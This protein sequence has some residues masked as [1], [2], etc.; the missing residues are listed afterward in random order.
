MS[1]V[2]WHLG[3]IGRLGLL[4]IAAVGLSA[5]ET[6]PADDG[7]ETVSSRF[8]D[9]NNRYAQINEQSSDRFTDLDI[10]GAVAGLDDD[11]VMYAIT[12]AGAEERVRGKDAVRASL[13]QTFG[14]GN[15][16][17]ANVYQWGLA[18]NTIVQIEDDHYT[19][20]D[21][22]IEVIKTLVVIEYRDGKRWREWRFKPKDL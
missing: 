13:G 16:I 3:A 1:T 11:F 21:G 12:D 15:W 18:D 22:G 8:Y 14:R 5:C 19:T 9:K 10:E 4:A 7:F 6:M 2:H 20:D 17:G